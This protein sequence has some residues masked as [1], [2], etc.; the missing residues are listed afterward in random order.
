MDEER[1][2]QLELEEEA[3]GKQVSIEEK[4]AL[5]KEAKR[6]YGKDW[7]KILNVKSGMDWNALKFRLG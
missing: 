2:N 3:M 5:I 4:K 6:R 7:T 1:L